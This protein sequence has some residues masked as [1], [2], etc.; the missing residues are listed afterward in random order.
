M[1][2]S[3]MTQP[4]GPGWGSAPQTPTPQP[5]PP[6]YS[7][8]PWAAQH[9]PTYGPPTSQH[10][11]ATLTKAI[12]A[13][14]ASGPAPGGLLL[15]SVVPLRFFGAVVPMVSEDAFDGMAERTTCEPAPHVTADVSVLCRADDPAWYGVVRF[16]GTDGSF[17]LITVGDT[18]GSIP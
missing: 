11:E 6:E 10:R 1:P 13:L 17:D 18:Q 9:G 2:D 14:V 7:A 5:W 3:A 8:P 4:E 16:T 12:L 15:S